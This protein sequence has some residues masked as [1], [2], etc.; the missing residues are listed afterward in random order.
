MSVLAVFGDRGQASA[1]A[2]RCFRFFGK[3]QRARHSVGYTM[4]VY[5]CIYTRDDKLST[6]TSQTVS[7]YVQHLNFVYSQLH[8]C[9]WR[10]SVYDI[11]CLNT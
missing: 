7:V 3:A 1:S 11:H 2:K 6:F 9:M 4:L 10:I 8:W 5:S